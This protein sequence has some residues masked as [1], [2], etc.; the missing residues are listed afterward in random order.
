MLWFWSHLALCA[1]FPALRPENNLLVFIRLVRAKRGKYAN[2]TYKEIYKILYKNGTD[3]TKTERELERIATLRKQRRESRRHQQPGQQQQPT[4]QQQ[5]IQSIIENDEDE[6]S[7]T[8]SSDEA[9]SRASALYPSLAK[10]EEQ[11]MP[12]IRV[13]RTKA[14][15]AMKAGARAEKEGLIAFGTPAAAAGDQVAAH[16]KARQSRVEA[17]M[18]WRKM[19][20]NFLSR[21]S[22]RTDS[23]RKVEKA[24]EAERKEAK[25]QEQA[26]KLLEKRE[27]REKRKREMARLRE[28][29]RIERRRKNFADAISLLL[30]YCRLITSFAVLVGNIHRTFLPRYLA[31]PIE[32]VYDSPDLLMVFTITLM[33]DVGFF[34]LL[35]LW[36]FC[37]QLGLCWRLGFCRFLFWCCGLIAI[38]GFGMLYPMHFV[39]EQ[40]DGTWCLFEEGEPLSQYFDG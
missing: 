3:L 40:L 22:A 4:Q 10:E 13:D 33:L 7:S 38:G 36:S 14:N 17:P 29:A 32:N 8:S 18:K 1:C 23:Q 2:K 15:N 9:A 39:H 19:L 27:R 16:N 24:K 26:Q 30:T 37:K 5:Q 20:P 12:N 35:V 31:P 25:K 6:S 21:D 11:A 34:W 28:Q